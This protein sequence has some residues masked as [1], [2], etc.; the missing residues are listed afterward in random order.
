[1]VALQS[2]SGWMQGGK[3]GRNGPIMLSGDVCFLKICNGLYEKL[4]ACGEV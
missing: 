4:T 3:T 1:M 2:G